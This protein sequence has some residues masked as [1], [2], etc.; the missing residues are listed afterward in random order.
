[1]SLPPK[2]S[3][4]STSSDFLTSKVFSTTPQYIVPVTGQ[5]VTVST[6]S[7]LILNP[8]GT[9]SALTIKFPSAVDGQTLSIVSSG[10]VTTLTTSGATF[11]TTGPAAIVAYTPLRYIYS[12]TTGNWWVQ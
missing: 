10:A 1:M 5:T 11:R 9:L 7:R 12:S 3:V 2:Q 6:T 4:G 8:A